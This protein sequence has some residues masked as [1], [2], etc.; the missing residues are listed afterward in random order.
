[1]KMYRLLVSSL[2]FTIVL[3][4][5]C[6]E[7]PKNNSRVAYLP[8]Y[9][10]ADFTPRWLNPNS[11]SLKS[12]HNI[13]PF[14]LT[15]QNGQLVTEKTFEGKIY[16]ADFFFTTCPGICP[17]M[18]NNMALLQEEFKDNPK[19][20]LLSHSITPSID[21]VS[22]LKEYADV[23]GIDANKWHITT[24]ERSEIYDLGRNY[25][26]IE[27]DLGIEKSDDDFLHTENF[28]LVD[29]NR[30]IRGIYNGLKKNSLKQLIADIYTLSQ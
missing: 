21:S 5:A 12:F 16:V 15:N 14:R 17:R 19:I 30:H 29:E 18:T 20:L 28:V 22:V 6:E 8:Y 13:K 24:G 11:D 3:I 1:M 4:S 10:S 26:F 27:E 2:I 9:N 25:Y 7:K 23:K